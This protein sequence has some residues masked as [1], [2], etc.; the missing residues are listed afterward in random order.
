MRLGRTLVTPTKAEVGVSSRE[1]QAGELPVQLKLRD[2]PRF[3]SELLNVFPMAGFHSF[4]RRYPRVRS[5]RVK[6]AEKDVVDLLRDP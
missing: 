4:E 2:G 5:P 6:S 1:D 3:R